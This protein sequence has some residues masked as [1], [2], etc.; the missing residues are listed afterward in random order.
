MNE[1][2]K[3]Y[4]PEEYKALELGESPIEKFPLIAVDEDFGKATD[5]YGFPVYCTMIQL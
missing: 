2:L 4:D 3:L 1:I 5:E